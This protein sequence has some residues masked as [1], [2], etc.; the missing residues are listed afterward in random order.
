ME[1]SLTEEQVMFKETARKF[2]ETEIAPLIPQMEHSRRTPRDLIK[3]MR[4][5]SFYGIQYPADYGGVG[6]S[7]LEYVMV[8]EE[9]SRVYCSIGGHISVNCLCAG[10]INDFGTEEQKKKYLPQ[11]VQGE[12]VGSFAFTEPS[13][14]SDPGAI[15]T[16]CVREG[17]DWVINGE[18]IFITNSTLPGYIVVFC[19][20]I[21][22]DGKITNII[23]PKDIKGYSAPKLVEKM[24]MNGMEVAD[25]VL[26]NVR[27]PFENTTGGEGGRGKGF[28]ILTTEIAIGKLGI[29]AECVG[30]A[31]GAFE[32]AV[33]YAKERVQRGKPIANFQTIQW[34]LG[35]MSSDV[36]AARYYTYATAYWKSQKKD[37]LFSSA[38]TRLFVSQACHRVVSSAMQVLGAFSYSKEF[39]VERIFRDMKLAEI[40]EGVNEIQRV[41]AAAEY[42]R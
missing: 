27:V 33:K 14:G 38:R 6:S 5:L 22:M 1:F 40:Y 29:S 17:D 35:E 32:E 26:D 15:R 4:D 39:N 30:M 41:M 3:K 23:V 2:A 13:T 10:T 9:L 36:E 20:D 31:Q 25:V 7:Y 16:T 42:I 37:I 12:A 24:G 8:I 18:K 19:K 21:E 34:L 28:G 11:L